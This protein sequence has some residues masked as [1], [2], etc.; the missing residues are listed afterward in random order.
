MYLLL[1]IGSP[2]W[3]GPVPPPGAALQPSAGVAAGLKPKTLS[4]ATSV[5]DFDGDGLLDV[6]FAGPDVEVE[7]GKSWLDYLAHNVGERAFESAP[8][9]PFGIAGY[10]LLSALVGPSADIDSDGDA[11]VLMVNTPTSSKVTRRPLVL[12]Q[13][14]RWAWVGDV[15]AAFVDQLG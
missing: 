1:F 8:V 9:G 2:V 10:K 12:L 7:G 11:D 4:L 14:S 6:L 3:D 5:A 13:P 15:R